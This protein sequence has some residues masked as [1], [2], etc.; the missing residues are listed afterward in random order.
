M[1][2]TPRKAFPSLLLPVMIAALEVPWFQQS[3]FGLKPGPE[4]QF[5]PPFTQS[6]RKAIVDGELNRTWLKRRPVSSSPMK[7]PVCPRLK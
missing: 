5:G 7:P 6:R 3:S 1:A 2:V 4:V